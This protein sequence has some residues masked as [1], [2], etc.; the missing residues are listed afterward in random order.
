MNESSISHPVERGG[1]SPLQRWHGI[2]PN[3]R[4]LIVAFLGYLVLSLLVWVQLWTHNLRWTTVDLWRTTD[5]PTFIWFLEWPVH[6]ILNGLNPFYSSAMFPPVGIN[7]LSNTGVLLIGFVLSPVTYFFGPIL[8]M[9]IALMLSPALSSLAMFILIRRWVRW[10]PAA[11]V[12]GFMYGFCSFIMVSLLNGQLHQGMAIFPPLIVALL[13]SILIR[14]KRNPYA[15]GLLLALAVVGQFFIA[16]EQL[17]MLAIMSTLGLVGLLVYGRVARQLTPERIRYAVRALTTTT[18]LSVLVLGYPSWFA[19]AGPAHFQGRVWSHDIE[20][21]HASLSHVYSGNSVSKAGLWD[22]TFVGMGLGLVAVIGVL[23]YRKVRQLW[24]F[25]FTAL[26]ATVLSFGSSFDLAPWRLVAHVKVLESVIPMRFNFF[27]LISTATIV[28]IVIDRLYWNAGGRRLSKL[29]QGRALALTPVRRAI[30]AGL[31]AGMVVLPFAIPVTR[32][33]PMPTSAIS[34][35]RWLA[36]TAPKLP[37]GQ[38]YLTVPFPAYFQDA[39]IWQTLGHMHW[40]IASGFGPGGDLARN[41]N[42]ARA[43]VVLGN[44]FY[45]NTPTYATDALAIRKAMVAWGVDRI[46]VDADTSTKPMRASTIAL[47]TSATGTAPTY[48]QGVWLWPGIHTMKPMI[49]LTTA[50]YEVCTQVP[51]RRAADVAAC[52][53]RFKG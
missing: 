35:P 15:L 52:V 19:L 45:F 13:D 29:L 12:G 43:I 32:H 48:S 10:Q 3:T 5:A 4:G 18:V 37:A 20:L 26:V 11:F 38:T 6:A 24:F 17:L 36:E 14:Q 41:P 34:Q 28:G 47:F 30:P 49:E 46:V 1:R 8:S 22:Q 16:T 25:G 27:A 42:E 39:A 50:H 51:L 9:N 21:L 7:L 53:M 33:L 2:S 40:T 31:V 44:M 23:A